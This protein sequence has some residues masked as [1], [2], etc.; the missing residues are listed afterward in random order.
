MIED[1]RHAARDPRTRA[2]S[3][4]AQLVTEAP[5]R[6]EQGDLSR[7]HAAGVDEATVLHVVMLSAF[8]GYL[9]R[10]ADAVG[11]ELDYDVAVRPPPPDPTTP[12]WPRPDRRDWPDPRGSRPFEVTMRAGAAEALASWSE[13]VMERDAPLSRAE[14]LL[15]SRTA[16]QTVGDASLPPPEEAASARDRALVAF[17]DTISL[18]PW[19]LGAAALAPLRAAGLDDAG[20]FGVIS[21]AAFT[22]FASRLDVALTALGR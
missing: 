16:A 2:L 14:R 9:N 21:V 7:A 1:P 4:L 8:F 13:Q 20:V 22:N 18:A 6:L 19:R 17:T 12:P 11:I 15:I 3:G 5:W 10:V